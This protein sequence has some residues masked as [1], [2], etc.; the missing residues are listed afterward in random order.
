VRRVGLVMAICLAAA[1]A[2]LILRV[3]PGGRPPARPV[4][5]AGVTFAHR[6]VSGWNAER[7]RG[8]VSSVASDARLPAAEPTVDPRDGSLVPGAPGMAVDVPATVAAILAA[9]PGTRVLPVWRPVPPRRTLSDA[10][11]GP[12][13]HGNRR[14][15]A[16]GLLINVA[17]GDE[18]I[19]ALL[20]ILAEEHVRA[21]WCLVGR[22]AEGQ[23]Q[24]VRQVVAAG[25]ELCNHG[26]SDDHG[27]E[28]LTEAE[29]RASIERADRAIAAVSG[30]PAPRWFSPH[31]GEWNPAVLRASR[32]LH[33]TLLLW[34]VDTVD[35][36]NPAPDWVVHRV[37]GEAQPGDIVLMH[38]TAV[39]ARALPE[40]IRG[41]RARGLEPTS[42]GGVLAER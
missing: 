36:R 7:L 22:W 25:H 38:P 29:A 10:P 27:W 37:V 34:S 11:P 1:V 41:L 12:V 8:L 16:V 14:R 32:A 28:Q 35:W 4:A 24:L 15:M 9:R 21:T 30:R 17:W 6:D 26:Y 13:R 5:A 18:W 19:P 20:R 31:K 40:V 2:A 42:V 33:H 3:R 39:M 23:P